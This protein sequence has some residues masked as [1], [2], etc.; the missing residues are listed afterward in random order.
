MTQKAP[1]ERSQSSATCF[2]STKV[3]KL[4]QNAHLERS[5]TSEVEVLRKKNIDTEQRLDAAQRQHEELAG[6]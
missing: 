5:F 2:T 1:P 6:V 3:Q 4:T